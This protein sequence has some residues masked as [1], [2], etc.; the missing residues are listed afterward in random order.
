MLLDFGSH[1]VD[2][3]L[4]LLGPVD[5]VY[6]ETPRSRVRARRRRVR[7]AAPTAAGRAR[8]CGASWS[9]AAP[10][11]RYRVTGTD[12]QLRG[13]STGRPGGGA[14]RRPDAGE[15]G[16][17]W[18][19]EAEAAWGTL[20][21]GDESEAVPSERGRWDTFYPAF[22]AAVRGTAP[23]P[24]DPCDAVATATVLDAARQRGRPAPPSTCRASTTERT[25]L[26]RDEH[27]RYSVP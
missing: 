19:P 6:A 27:V 26:V 9:Q 7:R 1:L 18:G 4:V 24:V 12:G 20:H 25:N 3:A 13:T 21:R 11:P 17:R 15:R 16:R 2:Q 22:A 23:V 8:T 14:G 5:A 10:G